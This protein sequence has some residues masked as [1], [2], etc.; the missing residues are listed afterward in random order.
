MN[1]E[2]V[3]LGIF[4]SGTEQEV[5]R[6]WKR[7][8]REGAHPAMQPFQDVDTGEWASVLQL[9]SY[10]T[11]DEEVQT[12]DFQLKVKRLIY[13]VF[14]ARARSLGLTIFYDVMSRKADK[15]KRRMYVHVKGSAAHDSQL[16][17]LA[18]RIAPKST[19]HHVYFARAANYVSDL[20]AGGYAGDPALSITLTDLGVVK[21]RGGKHVRAKRK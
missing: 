1:V 21:P 8:V 3:H 10:E 4:T 7:L 15:G 11:P 17:V 14:L 13:L 18:T 5:R 16:V 6:L 9:Y 2:L 20:P 12:K 19:D